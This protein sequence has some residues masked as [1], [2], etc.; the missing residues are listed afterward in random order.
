MS[1][2]V[3]SIPCEQCGRTAK[4]VIGGFALVGVA[5]SSMFDESGPWDAGD[6][7]GDHGHSHGPGGH[8]HGMDDMDF[9]GMG[10]F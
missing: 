2:V 10:D 9:G 4:K 1:E 3:Q 6:G 5:E 7:D 8:S